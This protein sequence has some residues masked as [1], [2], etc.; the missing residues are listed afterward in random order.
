MNCRF[1][2]HMA[3]EPM[4]YHYGMTNEPEIEGWFG[5]C[6]NGDCTFTRKVLGPLPS[7]RTASEPSSGAS[8]NPTE[9][10][11]A[12]LHSTSAPA[13]FPRRSARAPE[14]A[15]HGS[16]SGVKLPLGPLPRSK[17]SAKK[18]D[19]AEHRKLLGLDSG[20]A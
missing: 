1:L 13:P 10:A 20:G 6:Q 8:P 16:S 17:M 19:L 3:Y 2:H 11:G 9:K 12:S 7:H 18:F 5:S 14:E 4:N 15:V